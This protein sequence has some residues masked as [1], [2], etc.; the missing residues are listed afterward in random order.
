M[1][2]SEISRRAPHLTIVRLGALFG[3]D[4][5]DAIVQDRRGQYLWSVYARELDP[6]PIEPSPAPLAGQLS[7]F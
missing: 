4:A 1:I 3:R 6:Q 7:L 2:Q 5:L